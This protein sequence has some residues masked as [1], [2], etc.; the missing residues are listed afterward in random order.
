MQ[1]EEMSSC[2]EKKRVQEKFKGRKLVIKVA[3]NQP[4]AIIIVVHL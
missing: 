3:I 4:W 2:N 1:W